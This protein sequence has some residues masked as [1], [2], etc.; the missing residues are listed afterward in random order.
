MTDPYRLPRVVTPDHY[1]LTIAPDLTS[2]RF[3]GTT[4]ISATVHQP[5]QEIVLNA[6][7]L[8]LHS[9]VVTGSDGKLQ[10]ATIALDADLERATLSFADTVPPGPATLTITTTGTINDQ[11]RGFYRSTFTDGDGTERVIATTQFESTDARRAFPCWDEPEHKATFQVRLLVPEGLLGLSNTAVV[12][13]RKADGGTWVTFDKTMKMSTYLVAFVVGPLVA[14][15]ARRRRRR[16]AAGG[17]CPRAG[18]PGRLRPGGGRPR[19]PVPGRLLRHPVPGGQARPHRP[20]RLRVRRHG[21]PGLRD[22]PRDRA[23]GR[24]GQ[25]EPARA[26]AGRRRRVARDRPHVVR[27]PG[28]HEMVE[29]DLAQRSLRHLHGVD[30]GRRLPPRLG[31]LGRVQHRAG[32]GHDDRRAGLDPPDRVRGRAARP[33]PRACSMS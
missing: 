26:R 16:A 29:R 7:E 23:A 25:F 15:E 32:H 9:A 14:T 10:Q 33:T 21:E 13:E 12:D 2:C 5:V 3:E 6:V 31:A 19:A 24:R 17:V 27:R 28:D 22:V 11:L 8:E 4:V 20:S 30:D 18:A 1:E